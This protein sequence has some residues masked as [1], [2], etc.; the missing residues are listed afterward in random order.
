MVEQR[1]ENPCVRGSN[2]RSGTT[3]N[4]QHT[5]KVIS[6]HSYFNH[7]IKQ[8]ES[9]ITMYFAGSI[10]D[11]YILKT[12]LLNTDHNIFVYFFNKESAASDSLNRRSEQEK[13]SELLENYKEY[14]DFHYKEIKLGNATISKYKDL[15]DPLLHL[16]LMEKESSDKLF[17]D[18][19]YY[20][21]TANK[22]EFTNPLKINEICNAVNSKKLQNK[23]LIP[24]F[25]ENQSDISKDAII[26]SLDFKD[27]NLD[28]I[29]H[30]NIDFISNLSD[31]DKD[32]ISKIDI[33]KLLNPSLDFNIIYFYLLAID[34]SRDILISYINNFGSY[35]DKDIYKYCL[36]RW[37]LLSIRYVNLELIE[38]S[39]DKADLKDKD[40]NEILMEL[41]DYFAGYKNRTKE[42]RIKELDLFLRL[43]GDKIT[44][45]TKGKLMH[46]AFCWVGWYNEILLQKLID[47][48]GSVGNL[49]IK[50]IDIFLNDVKKEKVLILIEKYRH[51]VTA[52]QFDKALEVA[53]K[54]KA[55]DICTILLKNGAKYNKETSPFRKFIEE[56]MKSSGS[57]QKL[58]NEIKSNKKL[59]LET[60]HK[61][62]EI[63]FAILKD[64]EQKF[65]NNED[66]IQKCFDNQDTYKFIYYNILQQDM[67]EL[68]IDK[69]IALLFIDKI[70]PRFI[71]YLSSE[72]KNDIDIAFG[73]V[74]KDPYCIKYVS[75]DMK[76]SYDLGLKLVKDS[77]DNIHC[78]DNNLKQRIRRSS[79][80]KFENI[81]VSLTDKDDKTF[82][83]LGYTKDKTYG[84]VLDNSVRYLLD[85]ID[86]D[87]K[88]KTFVDLGSGRGRITLAVK[89]FY[90]ELKK[91]IGIELSEARFHASQD[92]L[93]HSGAK[94]KNNVEFFN[95]NFFDKMFNYEEFDIIFTNNIC[96]AKDN[97]NDIAEKIMSNCKKG[98]Y[99]FSTTDFSNMEK[100][101]IEKVSIISSWSMNSTISKY[102]L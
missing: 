85:H 88:D 43:Y 72:L 37:H 64:P 99:I 47:F 23:Y 1:T 11:C 93:K 36:A 10:N 16:D 101:L 77:V 74:K 39:A 90:P 9:K 60:V 28:R 97:N 78:I 20:I 82:E 34:E 27:Y 84:E 66:F 94:I 12:L 50:S 89:K 95:K 51:L 17:S 100:Y 71:K 75:E 4:K 67:S 68:N 18:F 46:E 49:L 96:F 92:L 87:K 45:E 79:D 98:T 59:L 86:I 61:N 33:E 24:F 63:L 35:I 53:C 41:V 13:D 56:S 5:S 40:F 29:H 57:Y 38:L 44:K 55:Y 3:I 54:E 62:P 15:N 19:D 7:Q 52:E 8:K 48:G 21:N 42:E 70:N 69:N 14:R 32:K 25:N 22:S 31:L 6:L 30:D 65:R 83:N 80:V 73:A 102:R 26:K 81:H 76:N 2:P 91:S 58:S